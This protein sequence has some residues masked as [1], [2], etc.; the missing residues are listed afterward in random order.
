MAQNQHYVPKYY[1]RWFSDDEKRINVLR[2]A[3]GEV[4]IGASVRG[5]SARESFYGDRGLE[6]R[7]TEMENVYR[8]ALVTAKNATTTGLDPA[9]LQFVREA[10]LFQRARTAI[11][12]YKLED[13]IGKMVAETY[14]L[15]PPGARP[16][17]ELENMLLDAPEFSRRFQLGRLAALGVDALGISD[18][19]VSLLVNETSA[20]FLFSDSPVVFYN[21]YLR[22]VTHEG[23]LGYFSPGLQIFFPLGRDRLLVLW[24]RRRYHV[25]GHD[26]WMLHLTC[27]SDIDA[28]NCLQLHGARS[29]V[30]FGRSEDRP[31]VRD[32]WERQRD[33][34]S[35]PRPN[36]GSA[37]GI[38][39]LTREP[40]GDIIHTFEP[41]LP[42]DL[43]LSFVSYAPV[44]DDAVYEKRDVRNPLI[45]RHLRS[46]GHA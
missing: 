16:N 37:P 43:T 2:K 30:Y 13:T 27:E 11:E 32:L 35:V 20:P 1:F 42:Y 15:G 18:L 9:T 33:A 26:G 29:S 38:D 17:C 36:V 41:Q 21:Q 31:Y 12:R 6:R 3:T 5:Q 40:I 10:T 23:V 22:A 34:L 45:V 46:M 14:A 24:D 4:V 28:L 44:G 39:A 19:E 7:I 8:H 25:T